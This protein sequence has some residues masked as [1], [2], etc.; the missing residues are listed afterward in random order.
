MKFLFVLLFSFLSL[1][2]ASFP[3]P[4]NTAQQLDGICEGVCVNSTEITQLAAMPSC[5]RIVL[6]QQSICLK[7]G[8]TLADVREFEIFYFFNFS[9]Q[10]TML[11]KT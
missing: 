11:Q 2:L 7:T 6:G 4:P 10:T 3:N 5:G 8:Y 9:E 1:Y